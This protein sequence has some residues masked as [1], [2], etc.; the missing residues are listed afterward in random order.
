[1]GDRFETDVLVAVDA[2]DNSSEAWPKCPDWAREPIVRSKSVTDFP[3]RVVHF[4]EGD[5]LTIVAVAYSKRRPGYWL[6]RVN[7]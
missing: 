1:M 7:L 4:V 5:L 6:D 2:A 3:C